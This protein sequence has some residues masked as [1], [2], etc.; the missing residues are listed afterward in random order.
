MVLNLYVKCH[1]RAC[2]KESCKLA[3]L[4]ILLCF[5]IACS[6]FLGMC[7]GFQKS[8]VKAS[9]KCAFSQKKMSTVGLY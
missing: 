4:F 1:F 2:I 9:S 5:L 8:K 6:A 3:L 7:K